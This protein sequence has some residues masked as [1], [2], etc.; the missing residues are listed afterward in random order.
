[1]KEKSMIEYN[2]SYINFKE[3]KAL[4]RVSSINYSKIKIINKGLSSL[5]TVFYQSKVI[6]KTSKDAY[7]IELK[8]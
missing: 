4:L 8:V 3:N 7:L 1:M 6:S 5:K 2:W